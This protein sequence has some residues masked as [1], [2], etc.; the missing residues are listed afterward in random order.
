MTDSRRSDRAAAA[1]DDPRAALF[2]Q[3]C[4]DARGELYNAARPDLAL[5]LFE[6]ALTLY[7]PPEAHPQRTYKVVRELITVYQKLGFRDRAH[8]FAARLQQ[9]A[10][11]LDDNPKT[12]LKACY[13][14]MYLQAELQRYPDA[15]HAVHAALPLLDRI[16]SG[17][18]AVAEEAKDRAA[19]QLHIGNLHRDCGKYRHAVRAYSRGRRF[20]RQLKP[21]ITNDRLQR[22]Y[23]LLMIAALQSAGRHHTALGALDRLASS[24]EGDAAAIGFARAISLAAVGR[25]QEALPL[26][27]AA[28]AHCE[29]QRARLQS[30]SIERGVSESHADKYDLVIS[31]LART[32]ARPAVILQAIAAAKARLFSG[33]LLGR[34]R[35]AGTAADEMS[36]YRWR[37]GYDAAFS[38]AQAVHDAAGATQQRDLVAAL[39][40]TISDML[41]AT[42]GDTPQ[43]IPDLGQVQAAIP[44][45]T[46]VLE[47]FQLQDEL[48]VVALTRTDARLHSCPLTL[49][50]AR[51]AAFALNRTAQ[52]MQQRLQPSPQLTKLFYWQTADLYQRIF[53]PLAPMLTEHAHLLIC[54]HRALHRVPL[55][56]LRKP[57]GTLLGESHT[58]AYL[59]SLAS[60]L[61]NVPPPAG[62]QALVIS[63]STGELR[64]ATAEGKAVAALFSG[65]VHADNEKATLAA[66]TEHIGRADIIHIACHNRFDPHGIVHTHIPLADAPL[67]TEVIFRCALPRAPLVVLSACDSGLAEE[68]RSDEL[69]SFAHAFLLAGARAVLVTLWPIDDAGAPILV[70]EFYAALRQSADA[71]AALH[72]ALKQARAAGLLPHHLGA[73][74]C[75]V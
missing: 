52:A 41:A 40:R 44:D 17:R 15:W 35:T 62:T 19:H 42:A 18:H 4:S 43:S 71:A 6:A 45:N 25:A 51:D 10:P 59:P 53:L 50:A 14:S 48:L 8:A 1:P 37:A 66:V 61:R 70:R 34:E 21:G 49:S 29:Q 72:T 28:V 67:T 16:H 20:L 57:D 64:H 75:T 69:D 74:K 12:A 38:A 54:P 33:K 5:P 46:L 58:V 30:D 39:H 3:L 7:D 22:K 47:L 60:L 56:V 9:M 11:A 65:A 55:A 63:N 32:Q 68:R 31:L 73:L 2:E 26:A 23:C 27:Q 13:N 24:G 36:A